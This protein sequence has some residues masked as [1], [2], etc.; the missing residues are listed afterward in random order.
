MF[1]IFMKGWITCVSVS[2]IAKFELNICPFNLLRWQDTAPVTYYAQYR[3]FYYHQKI[4]WNSNYQENA[5][6]SE[7]KNQSIGIDSGVTQMMRLVGKDTWIIIINACYMFKKLV[8]K[9]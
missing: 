3:L 5:N 1:M 4:I 9:C 7:E 6:H 8:E 2:A